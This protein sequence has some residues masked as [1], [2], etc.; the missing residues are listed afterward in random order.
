MQGHDKQNP[1]DLIWFI[2]K[3]K[4]RKTRA[5]DATQL[6]LK[7]K[8]KLPPWLQ[9]FATYQSTE[10]HYL[11]LLPNTLCYISFHTID[12]YHISLRNP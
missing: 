4:R 6:T 3:K 8:K 2:N 1:E 10:N 11:Q 9:I 7:K 12:S 5:K